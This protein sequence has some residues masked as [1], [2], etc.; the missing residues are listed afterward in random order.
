MHPLTCKLGHS[1]TAE[2]G[3]E[4]QRGP[5][6]PNSHGLSTWLT[7]LAGAGDI[8]AFFSVLI[9]LLGLEGLQLGAENIATPFL[10][11]L[12]LTAVST[13]FITLKNC[14]AYDSRYLLRQRRST[15]H[16]LRACLIWVCVA[17]LFSW[18]MNLPAALQPMAVLKAGTLG[19]FAAALWRILLHG[20]IKRSALKGQLSQRILFVGWNAD[21]F[22]VT[23]LI[24]QFEGDI[25]E[26]AG[27]VTTDPAKVSSEEM[28]NVPYHGAWEQ[29][30]EIIG[31]QAVDIVV[32]ADLHC[33]PDVVSFIAETCEKELVRFHIIPEYFSILRAGL[34][35]ERIGGVPLLGISKLPLDHATNRIVKR[36]LDVMG[37]AIGLILSAPIIAVFGV[38]IYLESPGSIFFRQERIG[39]KGGRF[40]MF[41]LRSM[42]PDAAS[43]DHLQQ[44]TGRADPRVLRVGSFMRR[45]NIDEVPQFWNVFIGDMTL[46]GPRPERTYHS[47]KLKDEIPHYNARYFVKPGITGWAQVCGLRGDTDLGE[48]IQADIFYIENWSPWLDL[49]ILITTFLKRDNAY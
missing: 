6:T 25:F 15:I 17:V 24:W 2:I 27:F 45:W 20:A 31:E 37:A 21:A 23:R 16:V 22:R 7:F 5:R 13:F 10:I 43:K 40:N 18:I 26:V 41:K 14:G 12:G 11:R 28:P 19:G 8:A 46:V 34:S 29:V 4:F 32:L 30:P 36:T 9:G 35:L 39:Q 38:L 1:L 48:R 49:E 33:H 42:R 47:H 3:L 44:S